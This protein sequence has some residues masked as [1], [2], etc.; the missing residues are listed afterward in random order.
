M[1]E[2]KIEALEQE[3]KLESETA[4]MSE[5][6]QVDEASYPGAGQNKEPMQKA[7]ASGSDTG[8]NNEVP[9]GPK[10]NFTKG[11]PSAKKRP[12]DKGGISENASKMSLVKSIY[13]KLDEMSKEEVQEVLNALNEVDEEIEFDENGEEI[14]SEEQKETKSFVNSDELDL[15]SDV[16]ALIDGEELSEEFKEKA[17]TIFEAAVFAKV[18][19]EIAS[20]VE[21]LEEQYKQELEEAIQENRDS[22]IE[23]VDDFMN[24]VIKEWMEENQLAIEKGIRSEIVEDFMV[25]LKNLFVEHY[26]DIPDEKVDLV[27]DLF[28][29]VEDLETALNTE[30][31]K[32][33][34]NAKQLKEYKKSDA[35]YSISE[36][37]T[38][39]EVE[40]LQKLA[41]GIEYEDDEQYMEKLQIIKENYFREE[42]KEEETPQQLNE[43]QGETE[44]DSDVDPSN[45]SSVEFAGASDRIS[46]YADAI[47]RTLKK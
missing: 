6:T 41:E 36:D 40:K 18:N 43:V 44:D 38:E 10:P 16:Q 37:L 19:E 47:S 21:R 34:D 29:K 8:V 5:E 46:K 39:V 9:D 23:K 25:G 4:Q 26:I 1:S 12:L 7:S 11:V 32:N 2:E 28:E 24:Y 30:I 3:E 15:G 33:I 45:D 20:R 31:D 13:D 14:V 42:V 17:A 35:I 27:D 22:T